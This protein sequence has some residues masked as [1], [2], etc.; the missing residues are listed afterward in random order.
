M[1]DRLRDLSAALG[2]PLNVVAVLGAVALALVVGTMVRVAWWGGA[3]GGP[4]ERAKQAGSLATWWA[5]Y[6]VLTAVVALGGGAVLALFAVAS[7]VGLYEFRGLVRDRVA[8]PPHW[9]PV[10]FL[11]VPAH[12]LVIALG[13]LDLGRILVP[14]G[15]FVT[16][17]VW[18]VL[19]GRTAGF[20]ETAGITF[21]GLMLLVYLFSHAALLITLPAG[22][23]PDGGPVGLVLFTVLLTEANDIAQAQWGRRLGRRRITPTVSPNK[24]WEGFLLGAA[25]TV[26]LSV[27]LAGYLTPYARLPAAVVGGLVAVGGFLGDITM[28]AVKRQAGV[29]DSGTLLPGQGG[30]LDRIDSLTFTGPVVYYFTIALYGGGAA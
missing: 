21:L 26:A 20:A 29:K 11:V 4:A 7:G 13:W 28:S 10:V 5:L 25:T 27:V 12:Y 3:G 23:N 16:L 22:V 1:A 6:L 15:A 2:T 14:V 19:A 8:P 18:L 30:V 17:L 9:W 24:T